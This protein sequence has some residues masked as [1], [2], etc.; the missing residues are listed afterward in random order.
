M[1]LA[2]AARVP[3]EVQAGGRTLEAVIHGRPALGEEHG[4]PV[5]AP[6]PWPERAELDQGQLTKRPGVDELRAPP[7][8]EPLDREDEATREA[9]ATRGLDVDELGQPQIEAGA[10]PAGVADLHGPGDALARQ[11]AQLADDGV[12]AEAVRDLDPAIV[13]GELLGG[14]AAGGQHGGVGDGAEQDED[15]GRG[16]HEA[17]A[18]AETPTHGPAGLRACVRRRYLSLG[19]RSTSLSAFG[20]AGRSGGA[21]QMMVSRVV[22]S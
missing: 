4:E 16:Q 13:L 9:P 10:H 22:K 2:R 17:D 21:A 11:H 18:A 3:L 12:A 7:G 6:L 1:G 20:P 15:D 5:D 8:R 14:F 19:C